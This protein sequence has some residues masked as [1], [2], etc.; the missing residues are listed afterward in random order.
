M[1]DE[2]QRIQDYMVQGQ[3]EIGRRAGNALTKD[4]QTLRMVTEGLAENFRIACGRINSGSMG[5]SVPMPHVPSSQVL[6]QL[7]PINFN[8]LFAMEKFIFLKLLLGYL[9]A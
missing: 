4:G 3:Q 2:E 5:Y 7:S 6:C 1:L 9:K 8:S